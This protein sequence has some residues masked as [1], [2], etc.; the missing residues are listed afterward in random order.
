M[1]SAPISVD[2][3]DQ[4]VRRVPTIELDGALGVTALDIVSRLSEF[5]L[6][7]E[8]ILYIGMTTA[9]LG[10]RIRQYYNTLLGDR[11]PHAGGHWLKTLGTLSELYLYH[12]ACDAPNYREDQLIGHFISNVSSETKRTLR[13]PKHPF[14]FA[15]LEYPKGTRK[16]HGIEKSKL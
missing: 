15:N 13:D 8:S 16:A 3:V 9:A 10:S 1:A 6:P 11:T 5:W 2:L 7:D 12:A 14:P 4:W